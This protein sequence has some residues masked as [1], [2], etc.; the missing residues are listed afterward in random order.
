MAVDLSSV[1]T[2]LGRNKKVAAMPTLK[3][4]RPISVEEY[5]EGEKLSDTRHEF[6]GGE[7]F[8]I[9][10]ASQTHNL[11]AVNITTALHNRLRGTSCRMFAGT[12]KLRVGDDFYYPDVL[13]TCDRSDLEPLY[14]ERPSLIVEVLSPGTVMRDTHEKLLAYQAIASL[15]EY[16]LVEQDRREIRIYR[17]AGASW[18]VA[19]VTGTEPLQLA[20]VDTSVSLDE[21]YAGVR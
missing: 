14:V 12:M 2:C 5:L 10:G 11:I 4:V 3:R 16:A 13:V 17:R 15:Q 1:L 6:V 9:V 20:S 7:V 21:I 18:D 19:S 8:S